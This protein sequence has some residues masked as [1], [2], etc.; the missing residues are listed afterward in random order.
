MIAPTSLV[1]VARVLLLIVH[2]PKRD[3]CWM[4]A[5]LA[6]GKAFCETCGKLFGMPEAQMRIGKQT[7]KWRGIWSGS[8]GRE[9]RVESQAIRQAPDHHPRLQ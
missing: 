2:Y 8:E 5:D 4:M 6:F 9:Y 3:V 7:G 1:M